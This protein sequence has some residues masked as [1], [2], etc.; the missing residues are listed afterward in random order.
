MGADVSS[1]ALDAA[2]TG[3]ST[4]PDAPFLL[5]ESGF[6]SPMEGV[7]GNEG[8]DH[9][10]EGFL[11]GRPYSRKSIER[12]DEMFKRRL[13]QH[14][15]KDMLFELMEDGTYEMKYMSIREVFNY[16]QGAA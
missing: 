1:A 5:P 16:V 7:P 11:S 3:G 4:N 10:S 15:Q 8:G 6:V 9:Y 14:R 2:A 13:K 12:R